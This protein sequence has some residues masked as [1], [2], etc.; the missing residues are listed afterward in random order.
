M[1]EEQEKRARRERGYVVSAK[2]HK[3]AAVLVERKERHPLYGKFVKRSKKYHVH[4]ENNECREGDFVVIEECR[5]ISK[6][7]A[8]RLVRV[9][10]PAASA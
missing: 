9:H 2:M 6:T 4:D 10:T 7:K 1:S 5:P 8:W 3:G